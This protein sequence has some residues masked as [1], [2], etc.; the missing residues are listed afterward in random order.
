MDK[1]DTLL[2]LTA[3]RYDDQIGIDDKQQQE[4]RILYDELA[5]FIMTHQVTL[6]GKNN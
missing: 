6:R 1:F 5:D 3:W 4:A 2:K